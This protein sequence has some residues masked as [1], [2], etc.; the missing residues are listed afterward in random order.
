MEGAPKG[1]P[2][3][4]ALHAIVPPEPSPDE[5]AILLGIAAAEAEEREIDD[6]TAR[7]IAA[8][9]HGGQASA[10]YSLASSGNIDEERVYR[11]IA[12]EYQSN[13]DPAVRAWLNWLGTYCL[14]R[15]HKGPVTGWYELT[16]DPPSTAHDA[17]RPAPRAPA[18]TAD[19]AQARAD[20]LTR[21]NAAA[22]TTLGQVATIVTAEG[23]YGLA[24]A[25]A[26]QVEP[27]AFPWSNA[28][29]W[30]PDEGGPDDL[31]GPE[32]VSSE[33][34]EELFASVAEAQW[35]VRE[36][37]GW[38]G[39]VRN[40]GQ[41]GGAILRENQYGRRSAW[42]TDSDE[43]LVRAWQEAEHEYQA[44]RAASGARPGVDAPRVWVGSLSDYVAGYLHGEWLDADL[45]A[46]ELAAAVQFILKNS[47]ELDAEEYGVFDYDGF[48]EAAGL[49]GE[50][51]SLATVA[52]VAQGIAE[53]GQAFAAWA[54]YVGPEQAELLDRF[55]DHYLGEWESMEAYAENL[56]DE[57]EAYRVIDE[58]PEWL[59]PYLELDVAGYARDLSFD[60]HVVDAHGSRVWVFDTHG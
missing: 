23:V 32:T 52:R 27:D 22:V 56:L 20:L 49:L 30:R 1:S 8:Q 57:S 33:A 6:T 16:A 47:H 54:A 18:D 40:E 38:V 21:L 7:R 51:P 3:E 59:R 25:E 11:E 53:H 45:D 36:E 50:Y 43:E 19:E 5:R 12:A 24:A 14:R 9:L 29:R 58:A 37:M 60:L 55:E 46:D 34:I 28:V 48:G 26:E 31:A 13:Y 41:A 15:E 10:L 44:F 2:A 42:T 4:Q 35:G 39:L 17:A